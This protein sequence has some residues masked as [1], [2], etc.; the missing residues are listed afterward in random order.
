MVELK[1]LRDILM[2]DCEKKRGLMH[3]FDGEWNM[4][5]I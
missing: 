2:K 1:N 3:Y 4:V 5:Y